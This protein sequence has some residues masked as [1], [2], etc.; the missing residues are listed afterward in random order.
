L[1]AVTCCVI[2]GQKVKR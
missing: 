1:A 2:L